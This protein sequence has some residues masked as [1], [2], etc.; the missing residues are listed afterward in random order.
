MNIVL[1]RGIFILTLVSFPSLSVRAAE[2]STGGP[3]LDHITLSVQDFEQ[4]VKF[5]DETLRL[6]GFERLMTFKTGDDSIAGY[7][8]AGKPSFWI[9]VHS[10]FNVQESIG[11]AQGFHVAF[12]APS[13][14]A[15]QQW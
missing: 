6:L 4:S 14:E 2:H 11:K 13:V 10:R 7:G 5:Y 1:Q 9:G 8:C 12:R 15:I 3:V